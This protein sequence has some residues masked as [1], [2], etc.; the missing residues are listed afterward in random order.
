M[1]RS[2]RMVVPH[3][4]AQRRLPLLAQDQAQGAWLPRPGALF[5]D[6]VPLRRG[7]G[8][9]H[10]WTQRRGWGRTVQKCHSPVPL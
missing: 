2:C 4:K 1:S 6:H 5:V 3:A 7:L 9:P 10:S 8:S